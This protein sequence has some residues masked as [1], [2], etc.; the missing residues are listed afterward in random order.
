MVSCRLTPTAARSLAWELASELSFWAY[1]REKRGTAARGA[2]AAAGRAAGERRAEARR[3]VRNMVW[4][5][6]VV[7]AEGREQR[8][9]DEI[10]VVSRARPP[11]AARRSL[12]G[13]QL[14]GQGRLIPTLRQTLRTTDRPTRNLVPPGGGHVRLPPPPLA[15]SRE[16]T[17]VAASTRT[18]LC[19]DSRLRSTAIKS[20]E[21]G[22]QR[23][24][25]GKPL[26]WH[27]DT[28]SRFELTTHSLTDTDL[29]ISTRLLT[30]THD[31]TAD[32]GS[33]TLIYPSEFR[34]ALLGTKNVQPVTA[35]EKSRMR[36]CLP[37]G[38]PMNMFSSI[39]S[40]TQR[41]AE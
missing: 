27:L 22:E 36:S 5:S 1:P 39:F 13:S 41:R 16:L 7:V 30:C 17:E 3:P 9:D 33:P 11:A 25:Q 2:R 35:S 19:A 21:L 37:G 32:R 31:R 20:G 18:L 15:E 28:M 24:K 10:L 23:A 38:R 8:R 6:V 4:E 26:L 34:T 29:H 40:V 12:A 14:A